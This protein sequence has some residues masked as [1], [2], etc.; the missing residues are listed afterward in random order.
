M[1]VQ[2]S[3][4]Y[5]E[6]QLVTILNASYYLGESFI[7]NKTEEYERLVDLVGARHGAALMIDKAQDYL[8][9]KHITVEPTLENIKALLHN[10]MPVGIGVWTKNSGLHNVLILDIKE[11]GTEMMVANL[12]PYT[13][14]NMWITWKKLKPMIKKG[15]NKNIGPNGNFFRGYYLNPLFDCDKETK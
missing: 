13:D 5:S 1:K 10:K 14:S 9:L 11:A 4:L 2:D 3:Q 12:Y 8:K 7:P 6:C 15:T